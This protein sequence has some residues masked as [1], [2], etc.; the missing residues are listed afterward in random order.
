MKASGRRAFENRLRVLNLVV[1]RPGVQI[2]IDSAVPFVLHTGCEQFVIEEKETIL[3][4][5]P[6]SYGRANQTVIFDRELLWGRRHLSDCSAWSERWNGR[7]NPLVNS[8]EG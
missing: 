1:A 5:R 2:D 7:S 4:F 3:L 8:D 6:L